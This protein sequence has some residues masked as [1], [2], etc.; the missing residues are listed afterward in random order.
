MVAATLKYLNQTLARRLRLEIARAPVV[1]GE[2]ALEVLPLIVS[3]YLEARSDPRPFF[4]I[5][6]G[7][8]DGISGDPIHHLVRKYGWEGILVEP[9][10][11][12]CAALER[13]YEGCEGLRFVRAAIGAESG[14]RTL[15]S[16]RDPEDAGLPAWAPGVASFRAG[17]SSATRTRSPTSR[18]AWWRSLSPA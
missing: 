13:N 1:R 12:A 16:I 3:H 17:R 8:F 2:A 14:A 18:S 15:Y 4:F 11:E 9:R 5:Q 7:A 6:I 10:A